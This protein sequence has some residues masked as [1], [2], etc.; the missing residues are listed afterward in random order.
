MANK[1]AW[2]HHWDWKS[3][4]GTMGIVLVGLA[5]VAWLHLPEFIRNRKMARL[6]GETIGVIISI[7][8][9]DMIRY[10]LEGSYSTV[11]SYEVFYQ[12]NGSG[13]F[14]SGSDLIK[15]TRK[16]YRALKKIMSKKE[17]RVIIRYDISKP[18]RSMIDLNN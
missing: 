10:S 2:Y 18:A 6:E 3:I 13:K 12:Y 17:R 1:V 15:G 4:W 16:N 14:L 11:D 5:I 7:K 8:E 9:N